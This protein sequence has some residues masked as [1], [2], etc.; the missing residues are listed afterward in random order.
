MRIADRDSKERTLVIAEIGNNHEGDVKVAKELVKQAAYCGVD[1]VKFQTFRTDDFVSPAD[2]DRVTRM[3]G[4][5]LTPDEFEAL[6]KEAKQHDLLF[7]STPLDLPSVKVL[8]PLVDAFKIA[9]GDNNFYPMIERVCETGKPL[10]VSSGVSDLEQVKQTKAYCESVWQRTQQVADLAVLHCVS[11][12]P[13]QSEDANIRAV[14]RLLAE[15]ECEVG[16]SDHTLGIE[17]C[18][19]S[20]ALGATIIEKHFTLDRQYSEFR[21]HAIA[22]DPMEMSQLVE[23]VRLAEQLLGDGE[24]AIADCEQ[25]MAPAIRRSIVAAR[26]L[27]EGHVITES[28]LTWM[29]PGR[30]LAPGQEQQLIGRQLNKTVKHGEAIVLRDVA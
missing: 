9:S 14:T 27:P 8:A 1:A 11:N 7:I 21:D 3:R 20:V 29:R 28:D 22:A 25:E 12:Y 4:F 30:G 2:A 16:Y 6:H 10:I 13:T 23:K 24:K 15:L 26:E 5:E 19:L 18:L 17:A